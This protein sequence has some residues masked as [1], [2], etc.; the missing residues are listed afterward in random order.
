MLSEVMHWHLMVL[1]VTSRTWPYCWTGDGWWQ[2]ETVTCVGPLWCSGLKYGFPPR[3]TSGTS[4]PSPSHQNRWILPSAQ[5]CKCICL[6][7]L[8]WTAS[9]NPSN[10]YL[11]HNILASNSSCLTYPCC[12]LS[13]GFNLWQQCPP[14]I[15]KH[16]MKPELCMLPDLTLELRGSWI[17]SWEMP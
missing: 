9:H 15:F 17:E 12:P 10:M 3:P 6:H 5:K 14:R 11:S 4:I 16:V 13:G 1:N 7:R 2:V 8:C